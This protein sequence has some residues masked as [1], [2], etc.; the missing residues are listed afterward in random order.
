MY[1]YDSLKIEGGAEGS[2]NFTREAIGFLSSE[3]A[4]ITPA[5][6]LGTRKTNPA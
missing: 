6:I 1:R 5:N 2:N 4:A 3:E